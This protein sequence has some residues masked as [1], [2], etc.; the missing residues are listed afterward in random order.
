MVR[1]LCWG[2]RIGA[3]FLEIGSV[4]RVVEIDDL[5]NVVA[6]DVRENVRGPTESPPRKAVEFLVRPDACKR[7]WSLTV[8][9]AVARHEALVRVVVVV[10]REG[11]LLQIVP[12]LRR[13]RG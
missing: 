8:G 12:A 4:S 7:G 1:Y 3:V 11:Q 10:G 6:F 5:K 2:S 13:H 9:N